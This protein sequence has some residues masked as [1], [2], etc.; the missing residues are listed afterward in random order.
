MRVI[1]LLLSL[2]A[3]NAH[4]QF[5]SCEDG[6]GNV[7]IQQTPCASSDDQ[8][9][10]SVEPRE[11]T[12]KPE[13]YRSPDELELNNHPGQRLR[14]QNPE[15]KALLDMSRYMARYI[16]PVKMSEKTMSLSFWLSLLVS[17]IASLVVVV[18]A[19]KVG[20]GWGLCTFFIPGVMILFALV[21]WRY[22]WLPFSISCAAFLFALWVL[23]N[24]IAYYQLY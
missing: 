18:K 4:A 9:S 11:T 2:F 23:L 24:G 16:K 10:I 6:S 8:T 19:F 13:S 22:A 14:P 7:T 1:V 17:F 15:E 20:I 21:H 5:Y 3:C 12:S